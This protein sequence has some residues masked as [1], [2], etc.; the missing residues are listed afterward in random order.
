MPD[1]KLTGDVF[2]P[3]EEVLN[4]AN[5]KCDELYDFAEKNYEGFWSKEAEELHW[6]Q[7]WNK[8]LDDS[9]MPF[10]KWFTEGKTN[11]CY[12]C[13]DVHLDSA[14]RN[15]LALIWEGEDGEFKSFS[16]FALHRDVNKFANVLKS[17]GV[18]KGDRV[19]IYMGRVPELAIAMLACARIG[20]VHSVVY[21]G[22][23][24]EALHERI[25]DSESKVLITCDGA[26]QRGK[27][28]ELK[29]ISD[30]ALQR[31]ATVSSVVVV[32]RTGHEVNMEPGRDLWYHDLMA[33]PIAS[34]DENV[35]MMDAEDP[36]FLLY[37]SGTT[38]KPK[39]ILHVHGGYM[40]GTYTTLKYVFDIHEEDRF[41]CAA[42]PGW[43]TGHSY[44]VYGP[45]L[46]GVT[47]FMYEGAP[48]YPYPSRWWQ[49]IEKYGINILY[50]APTAIRGL[51]RFGEAWP[52]RHD[53]SSL[54]LLG[55]VGEPINPEAWKW[56]YKVIGNEKCPVMDTWWQTET[57]MF[58]ITPMP[59]VPLK[60]GSGTKPFPGLQMDILDDEGKPVKTNEEGYLVIKN[61]WP[62]M[63]RTIW[64]DPDRYV[65]Q[66]WS[67]YDG[68][69]LTGDSAKRDEDG[70][71]WIIGR[72]D[73]VIKVSG[74]R[75]GS[76]EI[77]SALV[78]HPAVAE[79][80][81]IALPHEVKGN[82]IHAFVILRSGYERTDTFVE[83]LR[84]HVGHEMGPIAKPEHIDV[85]DSLP[86]TRSGKI[87]RRV[88][89][90]KALGVDPGNISTLAD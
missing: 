23:S 22:F 59:C 50:T 44:I 70:Y 69:Y 12:N 89:K 13:L 8:V 75:L 46:N 85:V 32:K 20:A 73:D 66:Y 1:K 45:L 86:K 84:K 15:K 24:V 39:A 49:I 56:Y 54:R 55:T 40:V 31:A 77:E 17:L 25:D 90:A 34:N 76:A 43:I 64:N 29:Q 79:A 53:L 60:P 88:L 5:A 78:S 11:I 38:G 52:N 36:L 61:P 4:H 10:F 41:W 33:L 28:I 81:A 18:S 35:E 21:G 57:G 68:M 9:K 58:M 80:A 62:S 26:Y 27:I 48:T 65:E 83:E 7:K 2:H 71:Y 16:Y 74:Y 30:E 72:V 3:T 51:M 67:K 42:D 87:M 14:R 6:F 37:T 63:L 47:S 82:A 19:T